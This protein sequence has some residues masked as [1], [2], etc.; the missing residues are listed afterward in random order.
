MLGLD[1]RLISICLGLGPER[2]VRQKL[3]LNFDPGPRSISRGG[4]D[5][6]D[7]GRLPPLTRRPV[8]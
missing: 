8:A 6:G 1:G 7:G 2:A 5:A 4:N 3:R